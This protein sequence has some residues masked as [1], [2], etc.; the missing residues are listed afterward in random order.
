MRFIKPIVG[1]ERVINKFLLKPIT[2]GRE[3]R[4]FEKA[5]IKQKYFSIQYGAGTKEE[6]TN[7]EFVNE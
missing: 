3:T 5:K 2:I 6:W 1:D 7:I 4:V